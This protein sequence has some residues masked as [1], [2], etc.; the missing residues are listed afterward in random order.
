[1][2]SAATRFGARCTHHGPMAMKDPQPVMKDPLPV[3][4]C[5]SPWCADIFRSVST[6]L[7]AVTRVQKVGKER[8]GVCSLDIR[9][10]KRRS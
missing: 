7:A 10:D 2:P 8:H 5:D 9:E 1:M 4:A 3:E 6:S